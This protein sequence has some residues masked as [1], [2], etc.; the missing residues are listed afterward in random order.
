MR[1]TT[2]IIKC[3]KY[4]SIDDHWMMKNNDL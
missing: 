1:D 3:F 2:L 4:K